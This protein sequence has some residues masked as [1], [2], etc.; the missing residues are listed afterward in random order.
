MTAPTA[1]ES[2]LRDHLAAW[3]TS[4]RRR[5]RTILVRAQPS[6]SG[7]AVIEVD[8]AKVRIVEG[9]SGLAA[10]DAMRMAD[11]AEYVAVLTALSAAELGTA[12]V[13]DAERQTVTDLDEWNIVPTLFGV[14]DAASRPVRDLGQWVPRLLTSLRRERGYAPAPGGVLSADHVVRSML[15]ALLDL[16]QL[17]A[18]DS[19]TALAPLDDLGVRA[20]LIDLDPE[21]RAGLIRAAE[22]HVDPHLAMALRVAAAS[23]RLSAISVGL[24]VGE[25]WATGSVSPDA[26]IAAARVR[27]EQYIGAAPSASAAQRYGTSA[28]LIAQRWLA[29]G[30]QH[31]R[32][33]LEQAEALYGDLGWVEGAA[34]SDF[35]PAGLRSRVAE[36]GAAI[37]AAAGAPSVGAS[38][39][40]DAALAVIEA[41][42][43]HA[44]FARS[45]VTARMASRLVRWLGTAT[46]PGGPLSDAIIAYV[47]DGAWAER[48]LGD[49]WDG[50]TDRGLAQAYRTLAHAV[51][52]VR[53]NQDAV[54]ATKLTG[55]LAPDGLVIPVERFLSQVVVPLA[56]SDRIL[57]I[58]LDGMS[59]PTAVEL[60][61]ELA[62]QG[63]TEIV[64]AATLRRSAAISA[65][66]TVTEY[67]RTSLFAGE[68]L[69]GNQQVE[70]SRF[71]SA[72]GGAL[73][74]KDDLRAEAG[75]AL[76][77]AV[78]DT[79]ADQGR[80]I[81]GV[82]L[83]TIDDALASADVDALRWTT[84]SVAHLDAILAAA[85]GAGRIVILTSD[86]GHVIERGSE[87][88]SVA[89]S[90]ARWRDV[91]TGPVADDEVLV[92]GPRVLV[93]GGQAVLAVSDGVRYASKK[94]GYHGGASLAELAIPIVV[95]KPRGAKDPAG[96]AEAPPQEPIWW[97]EP[98]RD[99]SEKPPVPPR[100]LNP[101][102]VKPSAG[103][104][105]FDLES[106][107]TPAPAPARGNIAQHLVDSPT[108][109]ARRSIAGR[110]PVDDAVAIVVITTLVTGAGRAH[111]D[112]LAVQAG[113]PAATMSGLLAALRRVLNVDGYP[114]IDIDADG[115]SVVL[116]IAL[117][118]EQFELGSAF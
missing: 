29:D 69:V 95:L 112:T 111:R 63:W 93:P 32:D 42:G 92:S 5:S 15:I 66:P 26:T 45:L 50:D 36:L 86:H 23:G 107:A 33:V 25:L 84:H 38:L 44:T 13:L 17:D 81:V 9:V 100:S 78:S 12:V 41:H 114:V 52:R 113:I 19:S 73:F 94:A 57:L 31:A 24:V 88:R 76:P 83:N 103:S 16:D 35:L 43:A 71:A 90:S 11:E 118:R 20:R 99:E 108:Y 82:V 77:P 14:R 58:V 10:L 28:K 109:K 87:L 91:T 8:G 68:L 37:D 70:K 47:A 72:V 1:T 6:W 7:A 65:L 116:D 2:A 39:A 101:Q 79:I 60:T 110:H 21:A 115:V 48:A 54:S 64:R 46:A 30:D 75:H 53:R 18:L 55:D 62:T 80:K 67:S 104:T 97:N 74:H 117:L 98:V 51:Q 27:A 96:W 56:A 59:A 22:I 3:L 85:H 34:A 106:D 40:V 89:Q 105:L 49:I 4:A 61:T 102:V